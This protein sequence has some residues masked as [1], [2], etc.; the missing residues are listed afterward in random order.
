MNVV[1][2][3]EGGTDKGFGH[4]ARCSSIYQAFKQY[5]IRPK[6]IINGDES[7]KSILYDVDFE[8]ID[9][10]DD[11][12]RIPESDIIIV[13]SY[14]V[15]IETCTFINTKSNLTVYIDDNNRLTYPEGIIVNGTLD[16]SNMNYPK[17]DDVKYLVGN[18]F[19]PL[20][21]ILEYS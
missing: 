18:E 4:V 11:L 1:I 7:L 5:N 17:R 9:W 14:L 13:D 15:D 19:I 16:I 12:S 10:L 3:T 21:K 6:F 8:I 2:L 20:R